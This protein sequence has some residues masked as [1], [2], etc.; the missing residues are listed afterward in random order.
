MGE[1][2]DPNSGCGG[3]GGNAGVDNGFG[4]V[5]NGGAGVDNGFGGGGADA[6][7]GAGV[8][9]GLNDDDLRDGV[10]Q[11]YRKL[12][13][14]V[15]QQDDMVPSAGGAANTG[16]AAMDADGGGGGG[17]WIDGVMSSADN[18]FELELGTAEWMLDAC[19]LKQLSRISRQ[20]TEDVSTNVVSFKAHEYAEKL[21]YLMGGQFTD[22]R[23]GRLSAR[24]WCAL[25]QGARP[26]FARVPT[27]SYLYGSVDESA[28]DEK[29]KKQRRQY[30]RSR[31][32]LVATQ[33][34]QV[35]SSES[36]TSQTEQL[37]QSTFKAL[38]REFKQRGKRPIGYFDFIIDPLS[39]GATVENM[40][41]VSF[42]VKEGKASVVVDD[43]SGLPCIEPVRKK[44]AAAPTVDPAAETAAESKQQVVVLINMDD[45][46][47]IKTSLG[48]RRSMISHEPSSA[49]APSMSTAASSSAA[50]SHVNSGL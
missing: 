14:C 20:R 7:G 31:D 46:E 9:N 16:D 12:I 13:D 29:E 49:A 40:F 35:Q 11:E 18:L 3:G 32:P 26:L 39:F 8:E 28:V 27:L 21:V 30:V 6:D 43:E 44:K 48:I 19:L 47:E 2:V 50:A 5:D 22:E 38:V 25:G 24:K 33:A 37:V 4:D 17:D 34:T 45:W 23:R 42:L 10:R 41:H 15:A 36:S 1:N